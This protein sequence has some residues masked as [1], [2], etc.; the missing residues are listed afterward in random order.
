MTTPSGKPRWSH[1]MWFLP[2]CVL[3]WMAAAFDTEYRNDERLAREGLVAQA[4]VTAKSITRSGGRGG[5]T[6]HYN[7]EFRFITVAGATVEGAGRVGAERWDRI[8][9][10][11]KLAVRYVPDDPTVYRLEE[12]PPAFTAVGAGVS[13]VLGLALVAAGLVGRALIKLGRKD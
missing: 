9:E 4:E 3:A 10:H 1:I 7:L 12:N 8:Q 13:L 11:D 5:S 2:V 6:T